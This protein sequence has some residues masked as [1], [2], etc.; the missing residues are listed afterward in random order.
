[1]ALPRTTTHGGAMRWPGA[2][3]P[4]FP[5]TTDTIAAFLRHVGGAKR[6]ALDAT[7][8]TQIAPWGGIPY[9]EWLLRQLL[10]CLPD[11]ERA[12]LAG[13]LNELDQATIGEQ[14][15]RDRNWV[16]RRIHNQLIPRLVALIPKAVE[17]PQYSAAAMFRDHSAAG[18]QKG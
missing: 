2:D 1:M 3:N 16:R 4:P 6:F 8:V 17:M 14:L 10:A 13:L 15:H 11:D 5:C 18:A 7:L 9:I 12:I